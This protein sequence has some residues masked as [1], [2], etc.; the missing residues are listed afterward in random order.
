MVTFIFIIG[1]VFLFNIDSENLEEVNKSD[2]QEL[3]LMLKKLNYYDSEITGQLDEQTK[4]SVMSFQAASGV[5]ADGEINKITL[6]M[7][8]R[9]FNNIGTSR[10]IM[11]NQGAK[12]SKYGEY[13]EWSK[14]QSI[15]TKGSIACI[16]DIRTG[17]KFNIKRTYGH[18]HADCEPLTAEDT[19][20][21]KGICGEWSWT[22]R[23]VLVEINGH[24]IAGS[25]SAMPH[26]GLD[27]EPANVYVNNRSEGYG[28]GINLDEV[29][30]NNFD[31]HFDLHFLNSKTH[32]TN[33]INPLHQASVKEAAGLLKRD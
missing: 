22:T 14:V 28:R 7:L 13:M 9:S 23:P 17:K 3:Q 27:S 1:I 30:D 8:S 16:T 4:E 12:K 2:I 21:M 24:F 25:A 18:N 6:A 19:A 5:V 11:V 32:A 33:R 15:F 29:K 31:G 26:A 20:I 10:G